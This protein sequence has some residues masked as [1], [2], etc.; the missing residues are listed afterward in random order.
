MWAAT[1]SDTGITLEAPNLESLIDSV[2]SRASKSES[3]SPSASL[4]RSAVASSSSASPQRGSWRTAAS[5]ASA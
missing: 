2:A 3:V 4:T 1:S 5:A